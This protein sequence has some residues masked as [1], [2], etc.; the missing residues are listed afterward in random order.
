MKLGALIAVE[1]DG[2]LDPL[3]FLSST[4]TMGWSSSAVL[5]SLSKKDTNTCL[6]N[7]WSLFGQLPTIVTD[8]VMTHQFWP[9]TK[10]CNEISRFSEKSQNLVLLSPPEPLELISCKYGADL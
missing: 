10:T 2:F 6:M 1:P 4:R 3:L 5:I 9:W 7:S 8:A